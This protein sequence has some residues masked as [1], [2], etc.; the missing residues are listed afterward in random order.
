MNFFC[1]KYDF[2]RTDVFSDTLNAMIWKED[3]LVSP[4]L[5]LLQSLMPAV[6]AACS[7]QSP[8]GCY[9]RAQAALIQLHTSE[10]RFETT[11]QLMVRYNPSTN[12]LFVS[13]LGK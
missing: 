11:D 1:T 13:K 7:R 12:R 6:E 10:K 8:V 4:L 2:V 5:K 9:S 3:S